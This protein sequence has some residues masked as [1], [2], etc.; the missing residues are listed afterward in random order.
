MPFGHDKKVNFYG[1]HNSAEWTVHKTPVLKDGQGVPSGTYKVE[2]SAEGGGSA[3]FA[4]T[5]SG[6]GILVDSDGGYFHI[7]DDE[8]SCYYGNPKP[9][10]YGRNYF[11]LNSLTVFIFFGPPKTIFQSLAMTSGK[12]PLFPKWAYGFTN[13]QW[14][15]D[16]H[17]LRHYLEIYRARDIPIDNFTLDFDW[18]DWAGAPTITASSDG[19]R[20]NIHRPC[21]RTKTRMH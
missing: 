17:L 7:N 10:D 6:Y 1:I 14:G 16:Q 5:T 13:S 12:M 9:E 19:I 20:L 21:F 8:I 18:K 15:T 2:A 4:W 3:L 11:R